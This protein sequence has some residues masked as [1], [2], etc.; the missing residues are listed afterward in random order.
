MSALTTKADDIARA[1]EDEIVS[2]VI[3]PGQVLRQ[4]HVCERFGVSRTPVREA[5][6]RL[7]ALGLVSAVPN[8]GVRVRSISAAELREAFLIRAELE[9]LAT[10]EAAARITAADLARLDLAEER[11]A[12]LTERMREEIRRGEVPDSDLAVEWMAANHA[13]HDVIY[14]VAALPRVEQLAKAARRTFIG[15]RV[16]SARAELDELFAR[17]DMQHRAI[18]DALAAGSADGARSLARDHV[19]SS[20]RLIE[21]ALD[22]ATTRGRDVE[23]LFAPRLTAAGESRRAGRGACR[24][25]P[26][27]R[28]LCAIGSRAAHGRSVGAC[29]R[30]GRA[31]RRAGPSVPA[32]AAGLCRHRD[33]ASVAGARHGRAMAPYDRLMARQTP[34]PKQ[35]GSHAFAAAQARTAHTRRVGHGRADHGRD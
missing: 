23:S 28:C 12:A 6:Q 16:L 2:G 19:L 29:A 22:L 21:A 1:L 13:F 26:V 15:G 32:H 17:N 14:E 4:E 9:S 18:R 5:L 8:R 27:G 25:R 11:F 10:A 31:P 3:P 35:G 24:A 20:G 30:S 7:E 34:R 33:T